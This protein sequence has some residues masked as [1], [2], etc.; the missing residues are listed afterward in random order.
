MK[1]SDE[2]FYSNRNKFIQNMIEKIDSRIDNLQQQLSKSAK[3]G[4]SYFILTGNI[5]S[6]ITIKEEILQ[7]EYKLNK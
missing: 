5:Q 3:F 1:V 2:Q 7:K 4:R 6:M